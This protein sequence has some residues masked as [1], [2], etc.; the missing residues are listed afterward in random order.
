MII[1]FDLYSEQRESGLLKRNLCPFDLIGK[2][3]SPNLNQ[4]SLSVD[5]LVMRIHCVGI[6][7]L[8]SI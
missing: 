7:L 4:V 5:N 3:S 1:A 8:E 6:A 2:P